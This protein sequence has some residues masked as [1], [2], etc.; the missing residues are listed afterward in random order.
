MRQPERIDMF[1]NRSATSRGNSHTPG[2]I[3]C[4]L[5]FTIT[6]APLGL[7]Q[8]EYGK[9]IIVTNPPTPDITITLTGERGSSRKCTTKG[10]G[11]CVFGAL[12]AA[13]YEVRVHD[14]II[15]T[16]RLL[17]GQNITR[18]LSF[19][20][21]QPLVRARLTTL[22]PADEQLV[23]RINPE[24]KGERTTSLALE[25]LPNRNQ[26]VEPLLDLQT[27]AFST[28]TTS[29]GGFIFNGQPGSQNVLREGGLNSTVIV[30][31]SASFQDTD[32]LFFDVKDRQ[33]IK[34]YSSFS[35]D[36][37]N[38]PADFGT[39]TGGQ[40]I[41]DIQAGE[42]KLSGEVYEYFANDVLSA[43]NFFD[44]ARKPP[45]RFNLFGF[46]LAGPLRFKKDVYPQLFG[47]I[48]YEGIRAS[49][50][51][52]IFA[53][54]PKLSL[55]SRAVPAIAP[56]LSGFRANGANVI[57][58][59]SADP[60]FDILK[61]DARNR[62]KRNSVTMRFDYQINPLDK[63]GL[64][65]IGSRA[66]EDIPDGQSGRRN[67]SVDISHRG[68]FNYDRAITKNADGDAKL[69]N[70]FIFGVINEPARV[71]ARYDAGNSLN[72]TQ[73]AISI[74]GEIAHTEIS[75]QPLP[76]SISTA[77]GLLRGDFDGRSLSVSPRQ[78]S[79]IDQM[80]WTGKYHTVTF[81]GEA[82]FL[83]TSI[84][85]LFGTTYNF[86][87]LTD[88]LANRATV[89]HSGDLGS[90]TGTN[91]ERKVAQEYY[92]AYLQDAWEIRS[93]LLLT[94]GL[95]YEYY[96]PLRETL[97]RF[98]NVDPNTGSLLSGDPLYRSRKTNF[99]PRLAFA[100]APKWNGK[101]A[102]IQYGPTVISGS[103]GMHVG[104]DVFN[105]ILSPIT[106]DR[107]RVSGADLH[108]P[109]D[110]LALIAS[111]NPEN[112]E[113]TPVALARDYQSPA[114]VYKFDFTVKR[115]LIKRETQS[116]SD[117]DDKDVVREMFATLSYVGN[118]SRNLLRRNFANRIVSVQTNPDAYLP[119]I[120][121]REF[122]IERGDQLLHPYGEFEF[123]STGGR[124]NY[125]SFQVSLKGRLK[126]YLRLFQVDYTLARSRGNTDGNE[127]IAAGDPFDYDYDFGYNAADVHQKLSFGA[128]FFFNWETCQNPF[129]KRFFT[130]W[131]IATIGTFQ[132]GT[133]IDVRIKRPNVVYIDQ[134]GN[135]SSTPALGRRA[136]LNVPGG[137]SSVAAYRPDL[138]P[139]IS[140][141]L[142]DDRRFLNPAAFAIPAPGT[143]GNLPRG[144]LR[145]PGLR[146]I[147][148]SFR[149]EIALD[150]E[151][152]QKVLTIN[153]DI[154][155]LFN[156]TNFRLS[157]ANLPDLLGTDVSNH[158]LQPG[159]PFT[160]L[161]AGDFGVANRTFKRQSDLGS[162]RQIQL[163]ISFK[164]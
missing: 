4:A 151:K 54:A 19:S 160:V 39:G 1:R 42:E 91:S 124:S 134:S 162:S 118:R 44:F 45:L 49:S 106:S 24:R 100:W 136:V 97:D 80:V 104:P 98:V 144:A 15:L 129:V 57:S 12:E 148:L 6:A 96:S 84:N 145:G 30:R 115:E 27:G 112:R 38:T 31:S 68:V 65:Y 79:F 164:F 20:G 13:V 110:P 127:A 61:L 119:A 28:G 3:V 72:L 69:H 93:N 14:T 89:E 154:T 43:R 29:F 158:E 133:P 59:A 114:R 135:V 62:A 88:F 130:N 111:S 56:L 137:G 156:F 161:G 53:A 101:L 128:L 140:P 33:S 142:N 50:G 120:V 37:S 75:E 34:K 99:L 23:D 146:L 74:D 47:F 40:L 105:N 92:I 125:D 32:A 94:Y 152:A 60:D 83:R 7:A 11:R 138:I 16:T 113:F 131:T 18:E 86:A 102:D 122:D 35:I 149:R 21:L 85:Q 117:D 132:T 95:R 150:K 51:N 8:T 81:G 109:A 159:H 78:F 77:G 90:F 48:N 9:I 155:N 103:F 70:Q 87:S 52:T 76:L 5:L 141:Y 121:K 82:R 116:S 67:V 25:Q 22:T 66:E 123:L 126:K 10:D 157:S 17:P 55:A 107:L 36:T 71:F 73:S 26:S 153:V 139:G 58:G 163:G 2:A 63:A 108:F 64:I 147:D 46:N 143:L 41:Q